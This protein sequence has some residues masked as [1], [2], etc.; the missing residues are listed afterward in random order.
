MN[1]HKNNQAKIQKIN[2][3]VLAW[4]ANAEREQKKEQERR[5]K[6]RMRRLMAEDEE[7]YRKLIDQKKDKRLAFLLS[8]TDEYINQLTD[9]VSQHKSD[10]KRR[11]A[12]IKRLQRAEEK[13]R[14]PEHMRRVPVKNKNTGAILKGEEA[15]LL[16]ELQ[17]WLERNPD[18]EPILD[19]ESDNES[20]DE[21]GSKEKAKPEKKDGEGTSEQDII[22][23][24]RMEAKGDDEDKKGIKGEANY[25]QMAHTVSEEVHEQATIM[26]NGKLKEYQV[27]GLEWMVS[28]HNNNLNGILADEMGLGKTIQT[29]GLITYLMEKKGVMGPFLIIVPL[30]TL[31]N[32][33][34][35][36]QRWAPSLTTLSYKGSP[37]QRRAVQGQIRS[38]RFNVLVTT[39]EYVIREKAI[40][41]KL[42]WKYM[43]IDEGHR[44]KNHNNKLTVTITQVYTTSHRIL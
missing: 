9:M 41:A 28:L 8:Q 26:V 20:D 6:E 16:P 11:Q 15:P 43:I 4:H 12:E 18:Y 30:S 33:M 10:H 24:A 3:A 23:K 25:Y 40:L 27:K 21:S 38:G 36:F 2:K 5:E 29:I 17:L 14:I 22:E 35:E 31:S 34:L 13:A 19:Y 32:W 42:R 7:G 39:Y 37:N 1:F 44:M